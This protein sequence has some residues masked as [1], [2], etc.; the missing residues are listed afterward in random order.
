MLTKPRT[1]W[2]RNCQPTHIRESCRPDML[3]CDLF[4]NSDMKKTFCV[5]A[6]FAVFAAPGV[7]ADGRTTR[8]AALGGGVGG[9]VGGAIGAE[10]GDRKGAIVGAAVGAAIGAAVATDDKSPN[11]KPAPVVV[12]V[13]IERRGHPHGCPPGL[14]K[15][16]RC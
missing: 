12:P 14:A 8:D 1:G 11:H 16:G 10:V 6:L 5:L 4:E 7:S 9:A 3:C 13:V 15:Q 2:R